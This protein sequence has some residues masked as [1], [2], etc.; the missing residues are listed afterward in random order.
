MKVRSYEAKGKEYS[1]LRILTSSDVQRAAN[2]FRKE[3]DPWLRKIIAVKLS[4]VSDRFSIPIPEYEL[5]EA[6]SCRVSS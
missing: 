1:A 4:Q 3:A 6:L 2:L 5:S